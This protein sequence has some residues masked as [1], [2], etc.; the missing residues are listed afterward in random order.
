[1]ARV[2]GYVKSLEEGQFFIKD[3]NGQIHQLKAG[4]PIHQGELVYGAPANPK[5]AKIVIDLTLE[6]AGDIML[7]GNS[8][9]L[10]D[11]S[12]LNGA[13]ASE[14]AI[15]DVDSIKNALAF[16]PT[17]EPI[18]LD[19]TMKEGETAAGQEV[20]ADGVGVVDSFDNRTG[21]IGNVDTSLRGINIGQSQTVV[22]DVFRPVIVEEP[23]TEPTAETALVSISGAQTIVEGNTSTNYTVS[24]DQA[25]ADV[26]TPITVN[27]TYS[28]VAVDGTDFTGVASVTIPA[29]SNSVDFKIATL[30]DVRAE[31]AEKFTITLGTI[32]DTNFENIAAKTGASSV[33]STIVDNDPAPLLSS[34]TS[35]DDYVNENT[36]TNLNNNIVQTGTIQNVGASDVITLS[37]NTPITSNNQAVS[38]AWDAATKTLTGSTSEGRVFTIIVNANNTGYTFTQL[39]AIDHLATLQGETDSKILNFGLSVTGGISTASF[40][41]TVYDDA[42]SVSGAKTITTQNDGSYTE[43]GFLTQATLSNDI[44]KVVWNTSTLPNLVYEGK[45]VYYIDLGNG[46]LEGRTTSTDASTAVFRVSI[47]PTTVDA[48]SSPKYTFDLLNTLGQLG[49]EGTASVYTVISGGNIA[50]LDLAFGNFLIDSMTATSSGGSVATVNTNNDWIGVDGNWFDTGDT[51]RMVFTDPSGDYGQVRGMDMLVEGQGSADYTLSW[52][53]TAAINAAGD[54]ITYSGTVSGT[55]NTDVPFSIPLQNGAIYFTKLEISDNSAGDFRISFSAVTANNYFSDLPVNFGYTL[56]DADGDTAAGA[57][58]VTLTPPV[59]PTTNDTSAS[60]NEDTTIAITLSGADTDGTVVGYKIVELPLNGTLYKDA[61]LTQ[62]I[63]SGNTVSA[64][65]VY[66]KPT[67]DWNGNTSFKYSAIDNEGNQDLTPATATITV[68]PVNDAPK[69]GTTTSTANVSE[70]GL[71]GGVADTL[72]IS[73][74]TN[75]TVATGTFNITDDIAVTSVSLGTPSAALASNGQAI[76]W[77]GVNTNNL[78]GSAGGKE[79]INIAISNTGAYTVTLKGPVDHVTA[80]VEDV[81]S[82]NIGVTAS[83]GTL[84]STGT[85]TVNIEDDAPQTSNAAQSFIIGQ[86]DTNL[87]IVLDVSGSMTS[88]TVNRLAAAKTAISNLISTYDGYG[89]VAVKIVTFSTTAQDTSGVWMTASDALALIN[90]IAAAGYTNY[91]AA[92]AQAMDSW[93]GAG[94]FMEAPV[95]GKLQNVAY[96]L[97]DG[98]PNESDGDTAALLNSSGSKVSTTMTSDSGIQSGEEALW[99]TFL[100]TNQIKS[101]AFGIGDGLVATDLAYLDPIA[102]DGTTKTDTS[103]TWVKDV[104]SLSTVLQATVTPIAQGNILTGATPGAVGADGGYVNSISVGPVGDVRTFTW[105]KTANTITPTGPGGST[106]TFNTTTHVLTI[107]TEQGGTGIVDLDDGNYSYTPS[108]TMTGSMTEIFGFTLKDNDGDMSSGQITMDI[109]RDSG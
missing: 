80:G 46:V 77:T 38:Y 105:D 42:P 50:N 109:T 21:A 31:G 2:I 34:V 71:A 60:G 19:E 107:T 39:K 43:S 72:G 82:L 67:A 86:Q 56:Q 79:I 98:K 92:L 96:F 25:A 57:I 9:L 106:Y 30:D 64:S 68:A 91:D 69:F 40:D 97:S 101:Y 23:T 75:A 44:T 45:T 62:V 24:V 32:T 4:D 3:A 51:L 65:T 16:Q 52:K 89:D 13:F 8:A 14:D 59:L 6:G 26:K 103:S 87:M 27:L 81:K 84:T 29:G 104:N 100:E 5:D 11:T 78:I 17:N 76:T 15:I 49:Q 93:K 108:A 73:D 83:D 41:V 99:K 47:D 37:S 54:T 20:A 12:L 35:D 70:E 66:F 85:L 55:G 58:N 102:Y 94:K 74:T 88:G 61:A 90:G 63:N 18:N 95:G 10:F 36:D 33:E 7:A 28:G 53:V 22:Q 48:N 1:M